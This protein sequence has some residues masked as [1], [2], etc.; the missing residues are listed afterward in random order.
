MA[1]G[2]VAIFALGGVFHDKYYDRG[3]AEVTAM[4]E[5]REIRPAYPRA[6]APLSSEPSQVEQYSN[7]SANLANPIPPAARGTRAPALMKSQPPRSSDASAGAAADVSSMTERQARP[8]LVRGQKVL[9]ASPNHLV[10]W[11]V[12]PGG[13]I[14]RIDSTGNSL[15]R[16]PG[17]AADL[18]AGSAL[19]SQLCW[20]VG[21]RGTIV[22]TTNGRDWER[23][24][25]PTTR[26]LYN[27]EAHSA[28][29]ATIYALDGTVFSTSDA[30]RTWTKKTTD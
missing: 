23:V 21:M 18:T 17:V 19:S 16:A 6:A 10:S 14:V 2:I 9:V 1:A 20:V 11:L 22:R 4:A 27:I 26:D 29:S 3:E 24:K 25:S 12:G 13:D 7:Q 28:D 8:A 5:R 15:S 30:G